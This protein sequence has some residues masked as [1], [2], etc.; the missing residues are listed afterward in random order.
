SHVE[1]ALNAGYA[2]EPTAFS[3]EARHATATKLKEL[4]L[5]LPCLMV[6]LSLTADDKAHAQ[7]LELIAAAG[8]MGRDLVPD[9]PPIL[10]TVLGGSPAKWDQQKAGMADQLRD[11]AAAADKVKTVIAIKAHVSSAV[12]SPERLMWLLDNVKSPAIQV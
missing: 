7:S 4:S 3:S 8:Q 10:E 6:H 12:N 1:F 2:T 9:H 5:K 11:W